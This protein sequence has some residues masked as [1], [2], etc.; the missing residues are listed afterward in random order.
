[1]SATPSQGTIEL[2]SQKVSFSGQVMITTPGSPGAQ[3]IGGGVQVTVIGGSFSTTVPTQSDGSFSVPATTVS[4]GTTFTFSVTGTNLYSSGSGQVQIAAA[5]P[6]T[7]SIALASSGVITFGSPG[8]TLTGTVTALNASSTSVPVANVPVYLNGGS[9]PVATTNSG[10]QFS[11]PVASAPANPTFTFSVNQDSDPNPLYTA[12][13][14]PITV[15]VT[16]GQTNVAVQP[17]ITVNGGPQTVIFTVTVDVTPAGTGTTAQ[18][19]GSGIPVEVT[20]D[21]SAI[22]TTLAGTTDANGVVKYTIGGVRPGDDYNFAVSGGTLYTNGNLDFAFNKESTNL[23]VT[24]SRASVTKGAQT[25]TFAGTATGTGGDNSVPIADAAVTLNNAPTP[26]AT[27]DANGDFSYTASAI[28]H[29][30]TYEFSIAGTDTYTSGS[31]S[32]AIGITA[33]VTRIDYIRVSPS[34]LKYGQHAT[35]QAA[36][37]Y[38]SGTTWVG[39]PGARVYLSEGKTTLGSVVATKHR[40]VHRGAADHARLRLDGAGPRR[41]PEPAGVGRR[42]PGHRDAA[43]VGTFSAG[44]WSDGAVQLHR[45]PGGDG[46]SP[47]TARCR[48]SSFSTRPARAARGTCSGSFR[49][50]TTTRRPRVARAP[51]SRTSTGRSSAANDNAYY[52]VMFPATSSFQTA[53]SK[54]IHSSRY[55]TRITGFAVSPHTLKKGQRSR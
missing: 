23:T 18:P 17:N 15:T 27:T 42:Q 49:C 7:T 50:T 46:A 11:Y 4:T 26:V 43:E 22:T 40:K 14:T 30:G 47:G 41:H 35:L 28:S 45:L 33:A 39:F 12:A 6:A 36:V 55:P 16:P 31:Q 53:V 5:A 19:I 25:V 3:S 2:G 48:A 1:M 29:A 44:L 13:S 37:Q 54:V 52:R 24:P 38:K 51:T 34:G 20:K 32:I 10:G 9:T 8:A 21:G